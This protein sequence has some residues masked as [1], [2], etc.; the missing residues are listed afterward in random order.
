MSLERQK[1]TPNI[2]SFHQELSTIIE[3]NAMIKTETA[4]LLSETKEIELNFS[5]LPYLSMPWLF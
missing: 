5:N 3:Q 1:K 2:N 4:T